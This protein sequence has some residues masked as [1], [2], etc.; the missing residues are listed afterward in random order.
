GSHRIMVVIWSPS[1]VGRA[2]RRLGGHADQVADQRSP[3]E[4]NN[5][6]YMLNAVHMS[7]SA[8]R[9]TP[10]EPPWSAATLVGGC[11]CR[12]EGC[13]DGVEVA[14]GLRVG[15]DQGGLGVGEVV[16]AA[17]LPDQGLSMAQVGAGH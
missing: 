14:Q 12:A 15:A 11:R 16:L 3:T 2:A 5:V 9:S 6:Q 4:M 17:E 7:R 10:S 13:A 1:F 8:F